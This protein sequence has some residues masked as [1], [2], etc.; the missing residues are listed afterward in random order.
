MMMYY[1][2]SILLYVLLISRK[3]IT[4]L[5]RQKSAEQSEG[6]NPNESSRSVS[7]NTFP[8]YTMAC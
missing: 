3:V 8:P 7:F 2:C 1:Y 4:E 6:L 5:Q